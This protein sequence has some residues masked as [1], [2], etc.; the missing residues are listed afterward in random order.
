MLVR[1][2][3]IEANTFDRPWDG[4]EVLGPADP[5]WRL[6]RRPEWVAGIWAIETGE[7]LA[8][9]IVTPRSVGERQ[10]SDN[11]DSSGFDRLPWRQ[12]EIPTIDAAPTPI[13]DWMRPDPPATLTAPPLRSSLPTSSFSASRVSHR[14]LASLRDYPLQRGD[15]RIY[16]ICYWKMGLGCS[17]TVTVTVRRLGT[18]S[19]DTA[20]ASLERTID[21][22]GEACLR[23]ASLQHMT[24]RQP[25]V[26]MHGADL[27][28]LPDEE[29]GTL[30]WAHLDASPSTA[31]PESAVATPV[32]GDGWRAYDRL[33]HHDP[34][35]GSPFPSWRLDARPGEA[36]PTLPDMDA[37]PPWTWT[38]ADEVDVRSSA[39]DRSRCMIAYWGP[40]RT[41]CARAFCP[42]TGFVLEH[43]FAGG[44]T[45]SDLLIELIDV[46]FSP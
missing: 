11:D 37:A 44:S 46:S 20:L 2:Q 38:A 34:W 24:G 39:I 22:G 23:A 27:Y 17:T 14:L 28:R 5:A 25:Y 30:L 9:G 12:L 26:L 31:Q 19:D 36:W 6:R 16:R 4:I 1:Q 3:V 7:R 10:R 41:C 21:D 29:S 8:L 40:N 18:L 42:G 32:T 15:R 45:G 33:P 43:H 13:D 35:T